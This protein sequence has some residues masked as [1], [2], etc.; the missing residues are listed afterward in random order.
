LKQS[1]VATSTALAASP[2]W[3]FGKAVTSQV[4]SEA[5]VVVYNGTYPGWPWIADSADGTLYCVFREG[6]EHGYSATGHAMITRSEDNGRTWSKA[7]IIVD[8]PEVDDRNVAVAELNGGD[9]L[10]TY[11][12][13]SAA[14]ESQAMTIR[15]AD[16][17]RTWSQPRPLDRMNTRTRSAVVTLENGTL[18]LPYYVAPGNGSL[19][20]ISEDGGRRW[21]TFVVPDAEG[22]VGDE[23]DV[24]EVEPD[25]LIG[26]HRNSH[27][28]GDGTFWKTESRDG[29]RK[30]SVP[31]PT[32]I[33]D[34]R[35]RSPAQITMHGETPT[36]IYADR[37]MVS[38]SAV[39]TTDPDFLKWDLEGRLPCYLYKA[40][41]T[42]I[43]DAS[44]PVS[45]P[46][47]PNRRLIVDYEIRKTTK[48]VAGYFV[49]FP[50]DW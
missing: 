26:I 16:G 6:T 42:A 43:A 20:A 27:P 47:G 33:R 34:R 24:L 18:V 49:T 14:K 10:V 35:S 38:V 30:W 9:L 2:A 31:K 8:E 23:W 37:R 7:T 11:N 28:K 4:K 48:R 45:A 29:G 17:G 5:D 32:N 22:F 21:K 50:A 41:E 19:A 3:S 46:V 15:S 25:R 44:Y 40:D 12:T 36:V 39:R 13:Y 1:V